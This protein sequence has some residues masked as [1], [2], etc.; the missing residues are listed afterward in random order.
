MCRKSAA[1]QANFACIWRGASKQLSGVLAF[2][3]AK[4]NCQAHLYNTHCIA[5]LCFALLCFALLCFAL[6]CFAVH[7]VVD[8]AQGLPMQQIKPHNI[9]DVSTMQS[10]SL[11]S[12]AEI[13]IHRLEPVVFLVVE[14]GAVKLSKKAIK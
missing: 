8:K 11:P 13:R 10:F 9:C 5:L 2:V 4:D 7:Y 1:Q 12:T 3:A 6:L 14:S